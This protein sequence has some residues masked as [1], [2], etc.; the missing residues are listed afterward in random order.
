MNIPFFFHAWLLAWEERVC[1]VAHAL[2]RRSNLTLMSCCIKIK[3]INIPQ[4]SNMCWDIWK[5]KRKI[6]ENQYNRYIW[7]YMFYSKYNLPYRCSLGHS[8]IVFCIFKMTCDCSLLKFSHL[9]TLVICHTFFI[10]TWHIKLL[11]AVIYVTDLLS[12][13]DN[14]CTHLELLNQSFKKHLPQNKNINIPDLFSLKYYI[15]LLKI[16]LYTSLYAG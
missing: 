13:I 1:G 7:I 12:C 15:Q 8:L 3:P 16:C 10:A 14:G 6:F 5:K 11:L 9:K 2:A 4:N